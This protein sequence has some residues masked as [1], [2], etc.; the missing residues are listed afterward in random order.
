MGYYGGPGIP[1]L[2]G[3][4]ASFVR[5]PFANVNLLPLPP[6]DENELD[7][8]LLADNWPAAWWALECAGQVLGDTVVVFGAGI[9]P[10]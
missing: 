9:F 8:L 7:Y 5:V 1:Q 2:N 3:G 10:L 6:G 4:Q